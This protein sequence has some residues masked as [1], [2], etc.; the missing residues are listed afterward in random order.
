MA[1]GDHG[2]PTQPVI[3]LVEL[4]GG[5]GLDPAIILPL[6]LGVSTVLEFIMKL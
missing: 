2:M 1:I 6:N 4:V 3:P 5:S